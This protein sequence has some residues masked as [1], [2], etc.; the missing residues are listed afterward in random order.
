MRTTVMWYRARRQTTMASRPGYVPA[1]AVMLCL[2][3]LIDAAVAV[4][5]PQIINCF[6]MSDHDGGE[7][8]TA[9]DPLRPCYSGCFTPEFY[10]RYI[11]QVPFGDIYCSVIVMTACC[12][13]TGDSS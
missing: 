13:C 4:V 5:M 11:F 12:C 9:E 1:R 7:F 3:R 2:L 10:P 8:V 6:E